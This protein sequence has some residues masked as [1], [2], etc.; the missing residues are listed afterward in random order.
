MT[1]KNKRIAGTVLVCA[2]LLAV[3]LLNRKTQPLSRTDCKLNTIVTVTLY[4][5]RDKEILDRCFSLCDEY[6]SL[7]SRTGEE[8]ELYQLNHGLL[9][10]NEDGFSTVDE[11]LFQ[12]VKD[13][14]AFSEK[15]EDQFYIG[16]EPLTS[17]WNFS[18]DGGQLPGKD[19]LE[20]ALKRVHNGEILIREPGEIKL[21][22]GAGIDLGATA[23]GY[24]GER[25]REEL[26]DRGVKS[27][28][29]SLG[30]NI[31]CI[32][33]KGRV[34]FQVGIQ[35]PFGNRGDVVGTIECENVSV[36]SSGIYERCFEKDGKL[37]HHI[38]NPESGYPCE[39][40]VAA[41]T[42]VCEDS[43]LADIYSTVCLT[44]DSDEA[45]KL[46][47]ETDMLEGMIIRKD[48][49]F[50]FSENFEEKYRFR[51]KETEK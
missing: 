46:L 33:K 18:E 47:N 44:L 11:E 14:L 34:P 38:L 3:L 10:E 31:V 19:E 21:T 35:E 48:G 1:M 13:G 37:Y 5:T 39:T 8:S 45:L 29:I 40:D 26:T 7:F 30:G 20:D 4:D 32:G 2:V 27:A 43:Y 23:K 42:I 15:S 22:G 25:I 50:L 51:R 41:V 28:V 49:T 9:P 24:I 6:E 16:M 12:L 36:V 17:L